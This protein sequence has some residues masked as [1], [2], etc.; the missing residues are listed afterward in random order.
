MYEDIFEKKAELEGLLDDADLRHE[1]RRRL[2]KQLRSIMKALGEPDP[3]L[4]EDPLI[5]KWERE[6]AEGKTPDLNEQ[7]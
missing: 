1:E 6:L 4:G 2:S 5:D 7:L 3:T